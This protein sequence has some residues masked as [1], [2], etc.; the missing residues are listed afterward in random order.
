[1]STYCLNFFF[2]LF[3]LS[4]T[5]FFFKLKDIELFLKLDIDLK[6]SGF[7]LPGKVVKRALCDVSFVLCAGLFSKVTAKGKA[8]NGHAP[9]FL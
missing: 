2:C 6:N 8:F 9:S 1:M 7:V 3:I 5:H 4:V